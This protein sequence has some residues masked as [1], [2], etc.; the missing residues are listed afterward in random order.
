MENRQLHFREEREN[1]ETHLAFIKENPHP[2]SILMD[3][4]TNQRNMASIFRIAEAGRLKAVYGY[5]IPDLND[6][7]KFRR[8]SRNTLNAIP[9][10]LLAD[11]DAVRQ[12][13][14]NKELIAVEITTSSIPYT[15]YRPQ[16]ECILI[17][18]SEKQGISKELL[19]LADQS[20]HIPMYG[21]NTSMNVAVAAGIAVFET[22]RKIHQ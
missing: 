15:E 2:I 20:I 16:K 21:L 3:G 1:L 7:I 13:A 17:V 12:I 8:I 14:N 9:F 4:L 10:H 18:G 11:L 19:Q 22:I 6:N 5:R